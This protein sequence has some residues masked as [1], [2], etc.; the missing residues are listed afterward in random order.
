[1]GWKIYNDIGYYN[2]T[3]NFLKQIHNYDG[4]PVRRA[5]FCAC[6]LKLKIWPK[7]PKKTIRIMFGWAVWQR[8]TFTHQIVKINSIEIDKEMSG[9]E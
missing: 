7:V 1:M 2:T 4:I 3:V 6:V 5:F 9:T 8:S